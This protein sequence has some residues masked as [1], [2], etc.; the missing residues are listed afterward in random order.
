MV[1][2]NSVSCCSLLYGHH[3][4][5]RLLFTAVWSLSILLVPVSA[6]WSLS[7]LLV[8][9]SAVWSL[10]ILLVA[11]YRCMDIISSVVASYCCGVC[12]CVCVCARARARV[13]VCVCVCV[14]TVPLFIPQVCVSSSTV[15]GD[16]VDNDC[17]ELIDEETL[18]GQGK[19]VVVHRFA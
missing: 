13:C 4:F 6:V 15:A 7:V 2:I 9:V 19:H 11:V 1:I 10:S 17:D 12:V 16:L 5:C 3:Q 14:L 8:P 18:N